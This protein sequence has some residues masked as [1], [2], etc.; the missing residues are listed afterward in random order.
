MI[1]E[2]KM[3]STEF[4]PLN[5][6]L[7]VK[8]EPAV[9]EETSNSGIVI[10]Y[11]KSITQRPCSG[12]II[13]VGL[14]CNDLTEGDYVVFP[15]TDGIDVKFLDSDLTKTYNEFMLLRYKSIIG[16]KAVLW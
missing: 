9:N 1:Q 12:T 4:K 5:E 14:D 3:K 11:R 8:V 15:D 10:Q 7:L 2:I 6:F 16:K 13:A